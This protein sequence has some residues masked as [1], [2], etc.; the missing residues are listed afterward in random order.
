MN[1]RQ[2]FQG[3][4]SDFAR[5]EVESEYPGLWRGLEVIYS[6]SLGVQGHFLIDYKQKL[7]SVF[8]SNSP[9]WDY[10]VHNGNSILFDG[11]TDCTLTSPERNWGVSVN[12]SICAWIKTSSGPIAVCSISHDEVVDEA[13]LYVRTDGKAAIYNHNSPN[14]YSSLESNTSTNIDEWFFVVGCI[15]GD[16]SSLKIFINGKEESG[17]FSEVGAPSNISDSTARTLKIGG[18]N[19][20]SANENFI[21]NIGD[22]LVYSRVLTPQEVMQLYLGKTPLV[23]ANRRNRVSVPPAVSEFCF[24]QI[25]D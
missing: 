25:I 11:S 6:P 3:F 2:K 22:V 7:N 18:R 21:G 15:N 12:C 4:S 24:G 9:V 5:S 13:L 16:Y 19:F 8:D 10:G 1:G 23:K 17:T 20:F 14:N